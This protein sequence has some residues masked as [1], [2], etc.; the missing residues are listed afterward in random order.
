MVRIIFI[1]ALALSAG[2]TT[3]A[4]WR[5]LYEGVRVHNDLHSTPPERAGQP[6]SPDYTAYER[7]RSEARP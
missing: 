4:V 1:F 7:M 3:D 2:C 5:G 6:A